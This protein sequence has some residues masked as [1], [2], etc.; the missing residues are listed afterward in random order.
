M[1]AF[2]AL[3][4]FS[5]G[6]LVSSSAAAQTTPVS[7]PALQADVEIVYTLPDGT[8]TRTIGRLFRSR[9][10]QLREETPLGAV[11]TDVAAGTITMLVK[12]TKQARVLT[13]PPEQRVPPARAHGARPEVFEETTVAGRRISKARIVGPQGQRA[14]FWTAP[15]LGV[16]TWMKTEAGKMTTTK[17]LRNLATEEPSPAMFTIPADYSV[18][19]QEV[20]LGQDPRTT[21]SKRP[22]PLDKPALVDK[23]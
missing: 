6:A 23:R 10:G 15:D 5:V 20:K 12:A 18:I 1:R 16:V 3:V 11:I 17:E 22:S 4:A 2:I 9:S 19:E 21:L 8:Q 7:V 14:E 13:I